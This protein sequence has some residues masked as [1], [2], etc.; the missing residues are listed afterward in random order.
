M[1][2]RFAV[3]FAL[4]AACKAQQQKC[5]HHMLPA[6]VLHG[7]TLFSWNRLVEWCVRTT[8]S[9]TVLQAHFNCYK[10]NSNDWT[11]FAVSL[12]PLHLAGNARCRETRSSA[13]GNHPGR[14][15]RGSRAPLA[16][17]CG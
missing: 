7:T 3:H 5:I 10:E 4:R 8:W 14:F 16:T 11:P 6:T 17:R 2:D 1:H 13:C 9:L 12:R 15:R